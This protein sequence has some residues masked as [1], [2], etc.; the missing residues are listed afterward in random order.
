MSNSLQYIGLDMGRSAVKVV[1]RAGDKDFHVSFPSAVMEAARSLVFED[2]AA[3]AEAD[4]VTVAG[5]DF[6]TGETALRQGISQDPIGRSD[7][8]VSSRIHDALTLSAI[9]RLDAQG[10]NFDPG[11]ATIVLGVPSRVLRDRRD[12]VASLRDQVARL[13]TRKSVSPRV[14]VLAQPMGVIAAHTMSE[15]GQAKDG[16]DLE[17]QSFAVIDVGQYTTDYVAVVEGV[18]IVDAADSSEG[19]E[20]IAL[21]VKEKLA[22]MGFELGARDLQRMMLNPKIRKRGQDIDL[23]PLIQEAVDMVLAP[24]II[25]VAK[26]VFRRQLLQDVDAVL[27]AGGGAPWV[28]SQIKADPDMI[29]AVQVANPREAVA[30]G[31]ARMAAAIG[32]EVAS[33]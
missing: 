16:F 8:W 29:H 17:Q 6:W 13:L 21:Q 28:V 27:V 15:D 23:K 7:E 2:L 14:I 24:K 19:V 30:D 18:P 5:Q 12:L 32:Q 25:Q 10:L 22:A 31:F 26:G 33:A 11:K 4:T 20:V 3:S 1:A 9:Q